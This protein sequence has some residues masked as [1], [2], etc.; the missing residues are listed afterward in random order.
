MTD[1]AEA[2]RQLEAAFHDITVLGDAIRVL[3]WDQAAIMP[4][5]GAA[6]R[7]EQMSRLEVL[8]H[9]KLTD[10]AVGG[11]LDAAAESQDPDP[12]QQANLR[13]MR[14]QH[15]RALALPPDLVAAHSKACS[16][17]EVIWRDARGNSD[18]PAVEPHLQEVLDL[19]REIGTAQGEKLGSTTYDALLGGYEPD[20]ESAV[21][22]PLFDDLAD[23][24]PDFLENVLS[25]QVAEATPVKPAGPFPVDAQR[26][27]CRRMAETVGLDL[28]AAR[29]DESAHPF[30]G[31]V[32]EDTRITVRFNE[33][34]FSE[35]L[36][37]V[38]HETGHALYEK[39]RPAKWRYQP[40][41]R[42][43]GMVVHESQSL[44]VEMLV[45]RSGEFYRW[46]A[47]LLRDAF[48][49]DGEAWNPGNLHR[50]ATQVAPSLIRVDADEVTYP[51]H[52]ILRYRLEKAMLAGDLAL[53]DLPGAWTEGMRELLGLSPP[54]D[55]QGCLQDIHW[56]AGAWGYFPT[57]TLGAITAAQIFEAATVYNPEI[58][59]AVERGDF[60]PL[61]D[62]LRRN[63]HEKGSFQPTGALIEAATGRP[64]E[65]AGFKAHLQRRYLA[66]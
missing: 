52:V 39:G 50:L 34:D 48:A 37:A 58:L 32:P 63:V 4:V 20:G 54:D 46:A 25:R 15:D 7:A 6:A 9:D 51:A 57:Y 36:M 22:D 30:S 24:L 35:A 23:F 19:T 66:A 56:Y 31:G 59:P 41:G 26:A 11:L 61:M 42:A 65:T 38:L 43:R 17:C 49:G 14:R 64:M 8:R 5:G 27:L 13:E 18:F 40:V 10:P 33:A 55:R 28:E 47:P 62:W 44:L 53:A 60:V 29:I 1:P 12:W 16:N 2:Y 21:I 3:Q 45:C